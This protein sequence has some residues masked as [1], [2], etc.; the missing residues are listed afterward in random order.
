MREGDGEG[1]RGRGRRGERGWG[2]RE[3]DPQVE[4]TSRVSLVMTRSPAVTSGLVQSLPWRPGLLGLNPAHSIGSTLDLRS[5]KASC[6]L[7]A[8]QN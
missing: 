3:D 6:R 8:K 2:E 1:G 7:Q 4:S 5:K